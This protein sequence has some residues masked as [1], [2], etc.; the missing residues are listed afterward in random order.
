MQIQEEKLLTTKMTAIAHKLANNMGHNLPNTLKTIY[1][2][3]RTRIKDESQEE[4]EVMKAF[5]KRKYDT[6][7]YWM[8]EKKNWLLM[9]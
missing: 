1:E 4:M 7:Y 6:K 3:D 9:N 8:L 5:Q 2:T